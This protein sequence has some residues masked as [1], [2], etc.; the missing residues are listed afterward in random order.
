MAGTTDFLATVNS[1]VRTL[2]AL[3][4][5]G[6]LGVGGWYGYTA[7]N[8]GGLE[9][10]RTREELETK[11]VE[12]AQQRRV[13]EERENELAAKNEQLAQKEELIAGQSAEI[14][15]LQADIQAKQEEIER[16]DI[17][18][19][20]LK[21]DH[22]LAQITV[23]DQGDDPETGRKYTTVE[24]RELNDGG[25]SL[26]EPRVFR[27]KGD[28]IYVDSWLVKFDDKYVEQADL[29]RSTTLCL[30][31]S[32]Y[33]NIDGPEG[34]HLLED[35][36][37]RP[38]AYARGKKMTEF[39]KTIWDDFWNI[40]NDPDKADEL[41]I[42][43]AHGQANFTRVRKGKTYRLQLRAS[44]GLTTLPPVDAPPTGKDKAT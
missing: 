14:S 7:Y 40:A 39:E 26:G 16:L 13:I 15:K 28:T 41:G 43:A 30:F 1:I 4:V 5:M 33:G 25:D 37:S 29:H 31:K 42:R 24:F 34:S 9:A 3:A 2:I 12:L 35:V 36:G 20:L 23:L 17:A 32:V 38:L 18:M 6:G 21:V 11:N 8:A 27:L 19:H 44:D 22:R 10:K